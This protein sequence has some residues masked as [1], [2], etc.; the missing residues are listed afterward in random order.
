M[1]SKHSPFH[2]A[3]LLSCHARTRLFSSQSHHKHNTKW[4]WHAVHEGTHFL[5]LPQSRRKQVILILSCL[6]NIHPARDLSRYTKHWVSIHRL[7]PAPPL[8]NHQ[9]TGNPWFNSNMFLQEY[10]A[11]VWKE[12]LVCSLVARNDAK[13]SFPRSAAKCMAVVPSGRLLDRV[14]AAATEFPICFRPCRWVA[15]FKKIRK[16]HTKPTA[17]SSGHSIPQHT[18]YSC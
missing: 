9:I 10:V 15:N 13:S 2:D 6:S 16:L 18:P 7:F 3:K 17:T 5:H 11:F 4:Q 14:Q 1:E 8:K 12:G